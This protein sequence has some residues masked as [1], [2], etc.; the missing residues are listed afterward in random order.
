LRKAARKF[1]AG[2]TVNPSIGSDGRGVN[3]PTKARRRFLNVQHFFP[4]RVQ[5]EKHRPTSA[6]HFTRISEVFQ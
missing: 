2:R 6:G 5:E 3:L 1:E 4:I